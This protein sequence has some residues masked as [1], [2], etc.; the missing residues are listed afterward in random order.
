MT[1]RRRLGM[2]VVRL[3]KAAGVTQDEFAHRLGVA[4]SYMSGIETG[5]RNPSIDLVEA[6][7][8]AL[9]VTPGSLLD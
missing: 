8:A 9:D 5:K 6:M 4:R 1:V 3:R 7:A 2:N